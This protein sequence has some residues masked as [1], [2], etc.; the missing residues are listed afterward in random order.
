MT[1][2]TR[3]RA[4]RRKQLG[5]PALTPTPRA[6]SRGRARMK[7]ISEDVQKPVLQA[8][9]RHMGASDM[10]EMRLTGLVD[11]AGMAITLSRDADTAKSLTALYGAYIAS[12]RRYMIRCIGVSPDAKTAKIE[13]MPE[14]VEV[15]PDDRPDI[16]SHDER[17]RDAANSWGRYHT[18]LASLSIAD[19]SYIEGAS[20]DWVV[21]VDAGTVTP[22]GARFVAAMDKFAAIMAS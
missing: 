1:K 18:A 20:R 21:L 9:A 13:M 5:L 17:D 11:A 14:V 16:R 22:A 10:N 8:R 15:R 2:A 7:E 12:Y 19:R 6:K 4:K 3:R